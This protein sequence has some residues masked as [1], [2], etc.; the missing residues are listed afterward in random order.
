MCQPY[1]NSWE[2]AYD[3]LEWD[4]LEILRDFWD[5][6]KGSFDKSWSIPFDGTTYAA[7]QFE[8]D[9]FSYV[10][11]DFFKR[12]SLALKFRQ[13]KAQGTALSAVTAVYPEIST[14]IITG[15]PFA[16]TRGY[17]TLQ[18]ENDA[19]FPYTYA[20]RPTPLHS[21]ALP[22]PAIKP[23]EAATLQAFFLAMGGRYK[24]FSFTDPV[25]GLTHTKV[26][27]AQDR[28]EVRH[29]SKNVRST[30]VELVEYA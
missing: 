20:Q 29:L 26:C 3:A 5:T 18:V 13:V 27:F 21:W 19:G 10:E 16:T 8:N 1:M 9:D 25:T 4:D 6:Q 23:D 15:T 12:Y 14:G 22:Y 28:L 7:C 11:S 30:N 24:Q 2:M 17:K